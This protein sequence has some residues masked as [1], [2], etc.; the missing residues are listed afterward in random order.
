MLSS[1]QIGYISAAIFLIAVI[2]TFS[3]RLFLRLEKRY[4]RF[5]ALWHLLGE[6]EFGFGFWGCILLVFLAIASTPSAA[7]DYL[8]SRDFTE[9]LFVF[10]ILVIASSR[11]ILN[12]TR[13]LISVLERSIP[14]HKNIRNYFLLLSVVP[15]MGSFIT[16]P[17]AMMLAALLLRDRYFLRP[18][19]EP[20]KYF[21][22]AVLLVNVSIGGVLTPYAAPPILMVA[23]TWGWGFGFMFLNFGL[24]AIPAVLINAAL[25]TAIYGRVLINL[26]EPD[27]AAK[28]AE[29]PVPIKFIHLLFLVLCVYFSHYPLILIAIVLAF[30]GFTRAYKR[31]Q[32]PLLVREG[33]FVAF[34]LGGLVV[35]GGMQSWWLSPILV[36][37]DSTR[38]FL[39][40]IA[41]T[42]VVDNAALTYLGSQVEGLSDVAKYVLVAGAVTGGGLTVI[43]NAP[44]PAGFAILQR[45]FAGGAIN[46]FMLLLFALVPTCIAACFFF[47]L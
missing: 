35:L 4:P 41:L 11:P 24:K 21:T 7:L 12:A 10:V 6:I 33:A 43:A 34:F 31:F 27:G 47:F 2:H 39:G 30:F 14:L 37:L 22:L 13:N 32:S 28:P 46:P 45:T 42:A 20:M 1:A 5:K 19:P 16:E 17:A 44:N 3:A 9:P 25:V 26:G 8:K 29:V 36:A 40:S 18:V 15:L 23:K 38:L